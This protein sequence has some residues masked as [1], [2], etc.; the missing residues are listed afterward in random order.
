MVAAVIAGIPHA[1]PRLSRTAATA[2]GVSVAA[3]IGLFGVLAAQRFAPP[4]AEVEP[5]TPLVSVVEIVSPPKPPV[6]K[7]P[8]TT[9]VHRETPPVHMVDRL[10]QPV[11][12]PL[13][14][15]PPPEPLAPPA[16]PIAG[17]VEP[18]AP[19]APP[20][21]TQPRWIELPNGRDMARVY[22]DSAVRRRI[23]GAATL[24]CAFT[25]SGA[26]RTCRVLAETPAGEGF[27][28]AALKLAPHFRLSPR[29]EDGRAIDGAEV[30]I[31]IR[32]RLPD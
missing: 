29:T 13:P 31:P 26:V 25:A 11:A 12:N 3:H 32:F 27:G 1:G 5:E 8:E 6:A 20:V 17:P 14:L 21:I 28:A 9:P 18:P 10:T 4:P 7:P 15:T 2:I 22:P 30:R 16:G 24:G 19:P 23:E